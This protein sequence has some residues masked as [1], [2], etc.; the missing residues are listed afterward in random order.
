ML[1]GIE[2]APPDLLTFLLPLVEE[3]KLDVSTRM[4]ITP[5]LGFRLIVL[6]TT[7]S[8]AFVSMDNTGIEPLLSE[9]GHVEL[10]ALLDKDQARQDLP[11]IL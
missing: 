5:K 1:R 8:D 2:R 4:K 9:M 7:T 6:Q 10:E 3:N 11:E